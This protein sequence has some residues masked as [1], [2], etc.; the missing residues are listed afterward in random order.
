MLTWS[1]C[2]SDGDHRVIDDEE[3]EAEAGNAELI[4]EKQ[5]NGPTGTVMLTFR[6]EFFRFENR[7]VEHRD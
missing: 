1:D 4:I 5:R 7:A 2:S 3:A 6:R